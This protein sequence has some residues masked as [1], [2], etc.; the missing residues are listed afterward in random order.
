MQQ[1]AKQVAL[2]GEAAKNEKTK[3]DT[4]K[5][6]AD[7]M[8]TLHDGHVDAT[9]LMALGQQAPVSGDAAAGRLSAPSPD[10]AA[11]PAMPVN[12]GGAPPM[13]APA[14]VA[15]GQAPLAIHFNGDSMAPLATGMQQ[16]SEAIA[17][18]VQSMA[19]AAQS[20]TMASQSMADVAG[21]MHEVARV[22]AAPTE[23][24]RDPKTMRAIGARK[25]PQLRVI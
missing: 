18:A 13:P 7:A 1:Q 6:Y 14:P 8:K 25:V 16:N 24:I 21:S 11:S 23:L 3:A 15:P 12:G 20:M 2:Q 4:A 9:Q 17:A 5:S 19:Q 10:V 22:A